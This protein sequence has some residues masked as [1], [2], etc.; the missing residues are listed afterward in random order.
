[1]LASTLTG[2]VYAYLISCMVTLIAILSAI[3]AFIIQRR[4]ALELDVLEQRI[5]DAARYE[6]LKQ[7]VQEAEEEWAGIKDEL[8]AAKMLVEQKEEAQKWLRDNEEQL[9]SVKAEREE[10]ERVRTEL[11]SLLQR[12][13]A[14]SEANSKLRTERE[15]LEF[16][17]GKLKEES[18]RLQPLV[19]AL[20]KQEGQLKSSISDLEG[21]RAKLQQL[22][23]AWREQAGEA[24][25]EAERR[26]QERD[27]LEEEVKSLRQIRAEL[28]GEVAGLEKSKE[29]LYADVGKQK[30]RL[31]DLW[32]PVL[33][34]KRFDG[35]MPDDEIECIE[36]TQSYMK[37]LGLRFP[38]RVVKAFHTSLK[39]ADVSPL[40]VLAGISG[41]G[42][43]EL[44]R[45]YAEGMGMHFLNIAV[46]P[47][48]DSPQDMFGFF[49]Y[50]EGKYRATELA[51]A[52][53]QMDPYFQE[54][55]RGW[56]YPD[57]WGEHNNLCDQMLLVLLDEMNL[58]RVEYYF[59][60][61]LSRLEIR[62]GVN[63]GDH[64]ERRK[65]EVPL[66]VGGAGGADSILYLF[67]ETNVL[68][69]GTMNEDETTQTLSDKV[70]DRANV[71]RFGKPNRL[72][73]GT[74]GNGR[75][76]PSLRCLPYGNW[77]KWQRGE[78]ELD[79]GTREQLDE[80]IQR[81]N[82]ILTLIRRPFAFRTHLAMRTYVANYPER[83]DQA[84][85]WAMADQIEQKILPKL[86]GLDATMPEVE[87]ALA[88]LTDLLNEL[89]DRLL[90]NA[91]NDCR[92][93]GEHLF[94]WQGVDRFQSEE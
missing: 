34:R 2:Q 12:H 47:R 89:D 83:T 53:V 6:D 11:E 56:E 22:V 7:R 62:R 48:W 13:A 10:Q 49:N 64:M 46:Q 33:D 45:R 51:R 93:S 63:T 35:N 42:K 92:G 87:Q 66:E 67:T 14:E 19:D 74:S 44:P 58:A 69:V 54:G 1:M 23:A 52:L 38:D 90:V 16:H 61:F 26:R 91:I 18:E 36:L 43:S 50:M 17:V 78:G 60:E 40:V 4:R 55:G 82:D 57:G 5:P 68:F 86:R 94:T 84:V 37:D 79:A 65:A 31:A 70:V 9:R 27:S 28:T 71:L 8:A 41:T 72:Q 88:R 3:W 77:M 32:Q 75:A 81:L 24:Q 29:R 59:S 73:R 80:W 20:A 39:V 15:S 76:V 25:Q 21:E 85:K 30:D